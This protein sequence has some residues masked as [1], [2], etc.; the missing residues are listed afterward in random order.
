MKILIFLVLVFISGCS[1]NAQENEARIV[2]D[3][4]LGTITLDEF[5][6]GECYLYS[7]QVKGI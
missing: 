5:I 6:G 3:E 2:P 4:C 7:K 1:V